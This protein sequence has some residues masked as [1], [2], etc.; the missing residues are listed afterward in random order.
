MN[1]TS[2]IFVSYRLFIVYL[3]SMSL[4]FTFEFLVTFFVTSP[5]TSMETCCCQIL[6]KFDK[7]SLKTERTE[8][9]S[10]NSIYCI[11]YLAFQP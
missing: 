4:N 2:N 10:V 1:C 6:T 11:F 8:I 9:S 7:L 3:N 5:L